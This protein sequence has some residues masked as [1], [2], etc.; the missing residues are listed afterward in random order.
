MNSGVATTS[1]GG[2]PR[3]TSHMGEPGSVGGRI[4]SSLSTG[5]PRERGS[6]PPSHPCR[7]VGFPRPD[8]QVWRAGSCAVAPSPGATG[9]QGE[10]PRAGLTLGRAWLDGARS[11]SPTR[12]LPLR[13]DIGRSPRMTSDPTPGLVP[14]T[15]L[16]T[17]AEAAALNRPVHRHHQ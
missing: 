15:A 1:C 14:A 3:F 9:D 11:T 10:T 12:R 2:H 16:V 13:R 5:F 17:I 4:R 8:L 7:R 6:F